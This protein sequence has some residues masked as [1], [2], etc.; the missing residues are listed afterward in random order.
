M[1]E[2][3]R[4]ALASVWFTGQNEKRPRVFVLTSPN[5]AEGKTTVVSNLGISIA[6]TNRRVLLVD[7]DIRKPRLHDIFGL[8]N[9]WGLG[10]LLEEDNPV[11]EYAF[12]DLACE[13]RVPGLYILPSGT[14]DMNIS[15][16]R[17]H[18]RL[19][20]VLARFRLEFHAVLIDTP[21][22]LKFA[23]ARLMGRLSDGVILVF[24]ASETSRDDAGL[25]LD[26]FEEDR[27][28]VL[29]SI[30]NDCDPRAGR[31]GYAYRNSGPYRPTKAG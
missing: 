1:A 30:L 8:D 14:G 5:P 7:G 9:R 15:S 31:Y 28:P 20:D 22:V 11:E 24:R 18:D 17:Y 27:T 12:E 19:A 3:F 25:A 4:T 21:P 13:T 2:S 23:D 16:L 6:N 26:R 29:G 10:N